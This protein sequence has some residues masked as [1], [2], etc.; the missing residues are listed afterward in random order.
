MSD[1][2]SVMTVV[3]QEGG[4]GIEN[5][6]PVYRQY[7]GSVGVIGGLSHSAW[8]EMGVRYCIWLDKATICRRG[9]T[10]SRLTGF[11]HCVL[12]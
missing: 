3:F 12:S 1:R 10:S 5:E 11:S 7:T 4:K 2:Q 6:R 8:M 9:G